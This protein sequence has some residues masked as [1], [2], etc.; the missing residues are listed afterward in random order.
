MDRWVKRTGMCA[1]GFFVSYALCLK[2]FMSITM[3]DQC[4]LEIDPSFSSSARA[5]IQQALTSAHGASIERYYQLLDQVCITLPS[6]A[7]TQIRLNQSQ[8]AVVTI[9]AHT[10]VLMVNDTVCITTRGKTF[11]RHELRDEIIQGLPVLTVDG[12]DPENSSLNYMICNWIT[13]TTPTLRSDYRIEWHD[14]TNI[15]LRSLNDPRYTI[16]C[17]NHVLPTQDTLTLCAAVYKQQ[18]G[19]SSRCTSGWTIDIRFANQISLKKENTSF[20]PDL[21]IRISQK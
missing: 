15:C 19:A 4:F 16:R 11:A 7:S 3:V 8:S 2:I 6:I 17:N 9:T 18:V 12:Y 14:Q 21:K 13:N 10:P 1:I 5:T 20:N